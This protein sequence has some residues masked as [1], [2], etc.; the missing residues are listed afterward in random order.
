M[1]EVRGYR[2]GLLKLSFTLYASYLDPLPLSGIM[3]VISRFDVS[4]A[5]M[6]PCVTSFVSLAVSSSINVLLRSWSSAS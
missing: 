3:P 6:K 1:R 4:S 2:V 5:A